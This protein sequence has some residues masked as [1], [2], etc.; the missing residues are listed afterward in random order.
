MLAVGT[1]EAVHFAAVVVE[2]ELH[3]VVAAAAAD[4]VPEN[5]MDLLEVHLRREEF[6]AVAAVVVVSVVVESLF[7]LEM[8]LAVDF[9]QIRAAAS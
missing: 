8:L 1:A 6:V 4:L 2:E 5:W 3:L 7:V 9:E